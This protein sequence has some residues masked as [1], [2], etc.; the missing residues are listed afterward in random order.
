V[1]GGLA[2]LAL[3]GAWVNT[4]L[5]LQYQREIAPGAPGDARAS[6][7]EWQ[8]RLGP[9]PRFTRLQPGDRLPPPDRVG[10]VVVIGRCDGL[11]RSSGGAWLP[12]EGG[13]E[14][15][16][17][18][19]DVT[20][21]GPLEDVE[22]LLAGSG[23]AGRTGLDL[24]RTDDGSV[25]PVVWSHFADGEE[26]RIRGEGSIPLAAG[27]RRHLRIV[28]DPRI[29]YAE[30]RDVDGGSTPLAVVTDLP[31]VPIGVV[32]DGPLEATPR[33]PSQ[34]ACHAIGAG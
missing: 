2:V 12:I 33:L 1:L 14:T 18:D 32:A 7:L 6:W 27:A 24:E 16:R 15:G 20:A 9:D 17:F 10:R 29:G 11:Y 30:V 22:A 25:V 8:A 3:W 21:R 26:T 23:E 34:L 5:G 31:A 4:S 19:L 13:A 28:L